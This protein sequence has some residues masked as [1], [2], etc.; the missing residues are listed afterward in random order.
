M[1]TISI[2]LQRLRLIQLNFK[3]KQNLCVTAHAH[4]RACDLNS[5]DEISS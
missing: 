4:L 3:T 1:F 5:D 2:V